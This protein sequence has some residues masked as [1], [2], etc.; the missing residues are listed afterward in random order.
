MAPATGSSIRALIDR[1]L[2]GA[3]RLRNVSYEVAKI[4]SILGILE[5]SNSVSVLP[6]L[7]LAFPEARQKFHFRPLKDPEI[8]REIGLILAR[9]VTLSAAASAFRD[10]VTMRA[11]Y[12]ENLPGIS[13]KLGAAEPGRRANGRR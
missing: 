5:H 9:G 12:P 6:A 13:F 11:S 10:L 2:T 3:K 8:K 7:A 4:S 1:Q